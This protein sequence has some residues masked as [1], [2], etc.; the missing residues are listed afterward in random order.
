MDTETILY[1]PL[2]KIQ[3]NGN[4]RKH[5]DEEELCGL[6]ES[7][8]ANGQLQ[9]ARARRNGDKFLLVDGERRLRAAR[10]AGWKQ[11]A[12]IVES[13]DVSEAGAKQRALV[14]N[15]QR[16][17]LT[18]LE[19]ATAI[20]ELM[21]DTGCSAGEA[22]SSL[23]FSAATVSRLLAL[24]RL[25]EAIQAHVRSGAIP[26]SA[27][28][29]LGKIEDGVE[30]AQIAA[31]IVAGQITRDGVSRAAK[32][33]KTPRSETAGEPPA[34]IRAEIGGGRIVMLAGEGL[35]SIDVMIEWLEIL[36]GRARKCRPQG[37]ELGTFLRILKDEAR[38]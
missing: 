17:D 25:P 7:M 33:S 36:L 13:D 32:R 31:K 11:L 14:S 8:V 35:E 15:C 37:L 22:A 28:Y 18:P 20:K 34:R 19:M 4:I 16:A 27:A 5:F 1:V 10:M 29:E 23:G 6:M 38:A 26:A 3:A 2:E 30:Q 24:V 21:E 12:V 9:P